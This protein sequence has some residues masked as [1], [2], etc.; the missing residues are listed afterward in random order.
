PCAQKDIKRTFYPGDEW[1][2]FKIY[3]G[4]SPADYIV[5]NLLL[6]LTRSL[7][8]KKAIN[9]WFF[10]RYSDP[11]FHLRIRFRLTTTAYAG[12]II[13]AMRH[14]LSPLIRDHMVS[15]IQIDTYVREL[16][17]YPDIDFS[18]AL[19]SS[20]SDAICSILNSAPTPSL[21]WRA[22]IA[23][24]DSLLN[25]LGLSLQQKCD[26]ISQFSDNYKREFGF[27]THNSR[28]LHDRYRTHRHTVED[29]IIHNNIPA[30]VDEPISRRANA[31]R[32]LITIYRPSAPNLTSYMHMTMNR[33]FTTQAR[34]NELVIYMLMARTY[35]SLIARSVA[36]NISV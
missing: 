2:Y 13:S 25:A 21:R 10:I 15:S 32:K 7:K 22:G 14:R 19:F 18:E 6:P 3:T 26:L 23:L 12:T 27:N 34:A 16:E 24:N 31:L 11:D 9:S 33:L 36:G 5:S 17:R 4:I 20:D 1:I 29:I 30:P 8:R 28:P 35:Q